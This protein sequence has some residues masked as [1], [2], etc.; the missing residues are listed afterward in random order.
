MNKK[1]SKMN[2][3][4]KHELFLRQ[5]ESIRIEINRYEKKSSNELYDS[6]FV[7]EVLKSLRAEERRIEEAISSVNKKM[8]GI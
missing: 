8:Y 7:S 6:A 1:I 4:E 5:L 2:L 3:F